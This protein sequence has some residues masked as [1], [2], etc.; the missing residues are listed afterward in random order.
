MMYHKIINRIR[1]ACR[2]NSAQRDAVAL[3]TIF[4]LIVVMLG[5]ADSGSLQIGSILFAIFLWP[6][7]AFLINLL[8]PIPEEGEKK[9][10]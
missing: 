10:E 3:L 5:G 8:D 4:N 6:S 2:T 7:V 9:H 1:A